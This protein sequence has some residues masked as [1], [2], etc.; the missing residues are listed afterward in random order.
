MVGGRSVMALSG[1]YNLPPDQINT[2]WY[3]QMLEC[4]KLKKMPEN[5]LTIQVVHTTIT[6]NTDINIEYNRIYN[7][8]L[9]GI[10]MSQYSLV[11]MNK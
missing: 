3:I 6:S 2:S 1:K 4:E 7:V 10:M 11:N 5:H 8:A 9:H